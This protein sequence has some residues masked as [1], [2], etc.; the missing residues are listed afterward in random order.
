[1]S[2]DRYGRDVL[3]DDP[4]QRRRA[5]VPVVTAERDL[6]VE[7]VTTG[8]CGA[9]VRAEKDGVTL[10]DRHGRRRIFAWEPAAFAVAG[11]PVTLTRPT[12][13][14]ARGAARSR[15]GSTVVRD[16]RPRVARAGRIYVEGVHDAELVEHVWGHDLR[17]EGVVVEPLHGIDDLVDVVGR[18]GPAPHRRLGVLVDHLVPGTKEHRLAHAVTS[19]HVLVTG[20]P[21]VD[22]WQAV[23]PSRVGRSAWP[24]V[25]RGTPW[26]QGICAALGLED[27]RV[28]WERILGS[29]RSY[30]D[31]E[32][33]MLRAVE[34][35]IDFVTAPGAGGRTG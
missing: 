26:K 2:T 22:V 15:S 18:F 27:E 12:S 35:L 5:A 31:L 24:N 3:A 32:P 11:R 6:V 13:G 14:P 20:H 10:E 28:A 8:W 23:R 21:F 9:V 19:P 7:H 29:V 16:A 33:A 34:Q 17:V 4:H 30:A 25:P 1:V